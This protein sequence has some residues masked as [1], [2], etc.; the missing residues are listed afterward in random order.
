M[1][2]VIMIILLYNLIFMPVISPGASGN[3]EMID[4]IKNTYNK[5]QAFKGEFSQTLLH[6]ESGAKEKRDGTLKFQKPLLIRWETA[7][8]NEEL[9]VITGKE[10]WDYLPE[11][12]IAYRYPMSLA[13]DSRSII[14][15][16]TG[17]AALSEDFKIKN[18]GKE[19]NLQKFSLFPKEPTTQMVEGIIWV[20]PDTGHIKRAKIIDFYGNENDISFRSFSP[21][22]KIADSAF[23]FTPPKGIEV[24][25]RRDRQIQEK[26]LFK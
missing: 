9:L 3:N 23:K 16:I 5:M 8:P 17:Q 4:K 15:V 20:S 2:K 18:L 19:N 11:E 21:E 14:Q 26:E 12:E 24:E 6:K 13:Q 1:P 25:D 10:I 22:N 7:K